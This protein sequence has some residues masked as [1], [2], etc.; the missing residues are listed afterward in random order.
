M[1]LGSVIWFLEVFFAT[2]RVRLVP[3]MQ[4]IRYMGQKAEKGGLT[5][6]IPC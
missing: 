2:M 6:Y 1:A 3:K 5:Y 4:G